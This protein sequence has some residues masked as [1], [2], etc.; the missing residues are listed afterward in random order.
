M[1]SPPASSATKT[2]IVQHSYG[3]FCKTSEQ[4]NGTCFALELFTQLLKLTKT[5][6]KVT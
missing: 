6:Q 5:P 1:E 4:S 3:K 2:V